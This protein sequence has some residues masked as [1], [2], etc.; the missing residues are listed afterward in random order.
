MI[1]CRLAAGASDFA[2]RSLTPVRLPARRSGLR[3]FSGR[4]SGGFSTC[5][6]DGAGTCSTE[7]I[8]S[9]ERSDFFISFADSF[10][11]SLEDSLGDSLISF[12]LEAS[13]SVRCENSSLDSID[14]CRDE[15]SEPDLKTFFIIFNVP[16]RN[17]PNEPLRNLRSPWNS[18]SISG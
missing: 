17:I 2:G 8:D 6:V 9:E 5:G 1:V 13:L 7:A 14:P 4:F 16:F 15:V 10:A 12:R 18:P 3:L 11:D